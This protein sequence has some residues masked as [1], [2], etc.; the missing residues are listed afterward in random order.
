ME[1]ML[2]CYLLLSYAFSPLA[3]DVGPATVRMVSNN[4]TPPVPMPVQVPPGHMVQQIVDEA[5]TLRHV[6]LSPQPLTMQMGTGNPYNIVNQSSGANSPSGIPSSNSGQFYSYS[7]STTAAPSYTNQQY[8]HIP[9]QPHSQGQHQQTRPTSMTSPTSHSANPNTTTGHQSPP[10]QNQG[11]ISSSVSNNHKDERTQKQY[12][13]LKK[14]L[15]ARHKDVPVICPHNS[16]PN[17]S[18]KKEIKKF[19]DRNTSTSGLDDEAGLTSAEVDV[20]ERQIAGQLFQF[21]PAYPG[22]TLINYEEERK[23]LTELL[24]QISQPVI[25]DV[26]SRTAHILWKPPS[27]CNEKGE[28]KYM[29]FDIKESDFTYE[30]TLLSDKSKDNRFKAVYN[31]GDL[32]CKLKD[33]KPATDYQ[34]RLQAFIDDLKSQTTDS[35][36]F[37]TLPCKPDAPNPPKLQSRT[38]TTLSLKWNMAAD[39]G[40]KITSYLLECDSNNN[41]GF[42]EIYSG[43]NKQYKCTKLTTSTDYKFRLSCVNQ[44]G[45]SDYSDVVSFSTCGSVPDQPAV[46]E[47]LNTEVDKLKLQ[48]KKRPSDDEFTLQIEEEEGSNHG[49]LPVYNGLDTTYVCQKLKRNSFYKFRLSAKNEEGSSRWSDTVRFRTLPSRP[50]CP[51]KAFA[52]TK[53]NATSFKATWDAPKDDGG[54]PITCYSLEIDKIDTGPEIIYTGKELEHICDHLKPGTVYKLRVSCSNQAGESEFSEIGCIT[55]SPVCP[56]QCVIPKVNGK[57]KANSLNLKWACPAY[58]GGTTVTDYEVD[59]TS[60]D[61]CSRSVYKGRET[62]CVVAGLLPGR[63]YIFRVRAFNRIGAG[64]WSDSME[65]VSG[66]GIPDKP[67]E[68]NVL[69]RSAQ[70]GVISWDEPMNNGATITEYKLEWSQQES[71]EFVHLYTGHSLSY[72]SK[73]LQPATK[74]NFRVQAVNCAGASGFSNV[75]SCVTPP[76]SPAAILSSSLRA[77]NVDAHSCKLTW[78]QPSSNGAEIISYNI[79]VSSSISS[80][81]NIGIDSPHTPEYNL[82]NLHPQTSYRVRVQAVNSVGVGPFS[83][84]LKFITQPLP[85][86]PPRLELIASNHNSLKL[87]FTS[88]AK[89]NSADFIHFCLEMQT[90]QSSF[91]QIYHGVNHSHKVSKLSEDTEYTFRICASNEAGQGPYSDDY[92]FKTSKAPPPALK[93]PRVVSVTETSCNVEWSCVVKHVQE[94]DYVYQLQLLNNQAYKTI[95]R[96]TSTTYTLDS[97]KSNSEYNVRVNSIRLCKDG[98]GELPGAFSPTVSF[99]TQSKESVKTV[100]T[101][102]KLPTTFQ[103]STLAAIVTDRK[104]LTDQ[105]WAIL[106]LVGFTLVAILVAIFSQQFFYTSKSAS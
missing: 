86:L 13:R 75:A 62:E 23:V 49:F 67:K 43:L 81:K 103:S 6:I 5:G 51:G 104:P 98:S 54:S 71:L 24:S 85:P 38:K 45:K 74:Y 9:M 65:T 32:N 89:P 57:P 56:G 78:Q 31:G 59:M 93:A 50:S 60:P 79:E 76:S 21:I 84:A 68:P 14:K 15:E 11:H 69:C 105:Q 87:R 102:G 29:D 44:L 42:V 55:T 47:L 77:T 19:K 41:E 70:H 97:L 52:K 3:V 66:A 95:Y 2:F 16:S 30:V 53:A 72:E 26:T 20:L 106:I 92:T 88:D 33:L 18:P 94:D 27:L 8:H 91:I 73:G 80:L 17:H 40:S 46:P 28:S 61:N 10:S 12:S 101:S 34:S 90:K 7:P 96:G 4:N 48:W 35:V 37:R 99:I 100:N 82:Q 22:Y 39:N 36:S 1:S 64:E 63:P 83:S 25:E 58:D